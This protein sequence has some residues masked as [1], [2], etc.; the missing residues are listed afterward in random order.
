[1]DPVVEALLLSVLEPFLTKLG[2][3]AAGPVVEILVRRFGADVVRGHLDSFQVARAVADE[4]E[5]L[6]FPT[7]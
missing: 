1:M 2:V 7:K 3:A 6:K 4:V 5:N